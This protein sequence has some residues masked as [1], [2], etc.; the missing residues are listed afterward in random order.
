MIISGKNGRC[1]GGQFG[2]AP[3]RV[4]HVFDPDGHVLD[5]EIRVTTPPIKDGKSG[6]VADSGSG[7]N[8]FLYSNGTMT[9]LGRHPP[10]HE[11]PGAPPA[12]AT[13]ASDEVGRNE[14]SK[15]DPIEVSRIAIRA[16]V[17]S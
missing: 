7:W 3:A 1:H 13:E 17:R 2:D 14:E 5:T 16:R 8:A 4:E 9:D 15:G 6:P 11:H 10:A 12:R